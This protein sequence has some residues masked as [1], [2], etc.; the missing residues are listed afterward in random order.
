[1]ADMMDPALFLDRDG[2]INVDHGYVIGPRNSTSWAAFS[3]LR[4]QPVATTA[5][6]RSIS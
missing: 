5:K 2:V 3:M 1:M 6:R 4:G